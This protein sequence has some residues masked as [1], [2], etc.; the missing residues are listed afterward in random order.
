MKCKLWFHSNSLFIIPK[1]TF[2]FFETDKFLPERGLFDSADLAHC[3]KPLLMKHLFGDHR[4]SRTT[5]LVSLPMIHNGHHTRTFLKMVEKLL[6]KWVAII[7]RLYVGN[8]VP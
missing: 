3:S 5:F 1:K 4:L 7:L 2:K 8:V 6:D